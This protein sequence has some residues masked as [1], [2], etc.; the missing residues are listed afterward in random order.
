MTEKNFQW[1]NSRAEWKGQK[2]KS[3]DQK[4]EQLK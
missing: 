2:K 1:M 4:K 3:V